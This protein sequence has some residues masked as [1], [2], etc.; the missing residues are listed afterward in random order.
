VRT[1]RKRLPEAVIGEEDG[2]RGQE[3]DDHDD[4]DL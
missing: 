1:E 2:R 4:Y 3:F